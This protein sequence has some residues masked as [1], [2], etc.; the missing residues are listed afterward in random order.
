[1]GNMDG[2]TVKKNY[3]NTSVQTR[4][5]R[6]YPVKYNV[7]RCLRVEVYG[8]RMKQ[9]SASMSLVTSSSTAVPDMVSTPTVP[10]SSKIVATP[11]VPT[12]SKLVARLSTEATNS[13][14]TP[15]A[16]PA[17]Q[18][19]LIRISCLKYKMKLTQMNAYVFYVYR[20]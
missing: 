6:I 10:T 3:F 18:G 14:S 5:I 13:P 7:Y 1:M 12:S 2:N 11:T 17:S 19:M 4:Y 16:G 9:R 8:C 20:M 15:T